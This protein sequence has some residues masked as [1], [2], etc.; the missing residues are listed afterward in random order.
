MATNLQVYRRKKTG[1]LCHITAESSSYLP[2]VNWFAAQ[3]FY[4]MRWFR[5]S[6]AEEADLRRDKPKMFE[7]I[8]EVDV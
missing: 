6:Q 5:L 4:T 3:D 1:Q 7:Y 2:G 8:G